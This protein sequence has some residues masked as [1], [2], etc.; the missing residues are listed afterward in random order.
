MR[1]AP[2]HPEA[3]A[4]R[5]ADWRAALIIAVFTLASYVVEASSIQFDLKRLGAET[6]L[7]PWLQEGSSHF[8]ILLIMPL[9][10]LALDRAPIRPGL[11]LRAAAAHVPAA[12]LFCVAHVLI[13]VSIRKLGAP[14][15]LDGPYEFGFADPQVWLY[16]FRKDALT[17]AIFLMVFSTSRTQEQRALEA[18]ARTEDA[19]HDRRLTL[20]SGGKTV[21]VNAA[22]VIAAKAASNYV[23]IVAPG[24]THLVRM[25]LSE[26]ER[27]LE[28]AGGE[29]VRV[30]RSHIVHAGHIR[31]I[32]PAGEGG[33][34]ILL[35]TGETIPGSRSYRERLP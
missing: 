19:R 7:W 22:D 3:L 13:M 6:P 4:D 26:L 14:Y 10:P 16:E 30:H 29:H 15:T 23:E 31:E 27:L 34:S 28:E 2:R 20:K 8:A 24:R 17:Y 12:A 25:T 35:D 11:L 32:T 21:F 5:R 18:I 33:V 1:N 9:A